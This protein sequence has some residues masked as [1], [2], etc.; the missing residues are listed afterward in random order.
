V[1]DVVDG[2][3]QARHRVVVIG[4][5]FGGV[6]AAR[7]LRGAPVDVTVVDRTNYHLF[8]PLLYQVATGI[9]SEGLIAPALRSVVKQ[10]NARV[11]LAEVTAIDL[12][13]RV[14]SAVAADGRRLLLTYDTLVVA[15]GATHAYFGRDE[16]AQFA[17][18]MKTLG[19]ARRLRSHILSAFE[20]AE[21]AT[22]PAE[23]AEYMTFVVI[24]A[25]PTG[26][27]LVGQ[28]AELAHKL[29][30]GDYRSVDTSEARIV[31]V[32]AAGAV[33]PPFAP[34]LQR[35]ARR[36]LEKMG[37]EVRT[38]TMAVDMDAQSITVEGREGELERIAARTRIW[39]A[40]V[41]A[42][43]LAEATG[44]ETDRAGRVAVL[45]DCTLPG[46]PEVFAI[47][48]MVL[49]NELPGVAQP[50]IQEGKYVAKLTAARL[51]GG[52]TPGPFTYFDKGSMATIGH[53]HAVAEARGLKFTGL[54][55]YTMWGF[56][57]VSYL[58]GWGNRLGTMYTWARAL[59]FSN[60]RGHRI[61][62]VQEARDEVGREPPAPAAAPGTRREVR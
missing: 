35:Y 46:H 61:I 25:G 58:V 38:N 8:Q 62:S 7:A 57:H 13:G 41:R 3:A 24:G 59:T 51:A 48:D 9:L 30:P 2:T 36:R 5:G 53:L 60:T 14:V 15:G 32:E 27:E 6:N 55:G 16:W 40:G 20:M 31:L 44:A 39:A 56:I 37:V 4:G 34:R 33:L 52:P 22:D 54:L 26:V 12:D 23:R 45:P 11:L 21:L 17:P 19:D 10:R 1:V 47:G 29:L 43:P 28:L 18:G 42:S 50:A 49:L